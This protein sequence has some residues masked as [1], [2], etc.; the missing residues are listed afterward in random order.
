MRKI[1]IKAGAYGFRTSSGRV[2]PVAKG[3]RVEV[4]DE[5]AT[6]LV[7]LGAAAFADALDTPP[8]AAQ[9]GSE[10][11]NPSTG[12]AGGNPPGE[13]A[14]EGGKELP[15]SRD[16]AVARLERLSKADLE[17]MA[18]DAGV[19]ISG[20]KNNRERAVLLVDAEPQDDGM[21]P[22]QTGGDIVT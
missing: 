10:Q 19:D 15:S 12:T 14:P 7:N 21:P 11:P 1:V 22:D 17:Q 3:E 16:E 5:E 4:S 20:A 8:A 6:R 13:P 2:R 18:K 9:G